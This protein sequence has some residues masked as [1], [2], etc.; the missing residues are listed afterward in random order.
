MDWLNAAGIV[1]SMVVSIASLSISL[2]NLRV[3]RQKD[4]RRIK[5]TLTFGIVPTRRGTAQPVLLIRATNPGDRSVTLAS[6]GILLPNNKH[7]VFLEPISNVQFPYELAEGKSCETV[8]PV[9][10]IAQMLQRQHGYSGELMLRGY[11]DNSLGGK[12]ISEE[13]KFNVD[14]LAA[15]NVE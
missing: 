13:L 8:T 6:P 15:L 3:A 2:Y 7:M 5:V 11:Y 1:T 10:E 12:Y 9:K 14:E 4:Q